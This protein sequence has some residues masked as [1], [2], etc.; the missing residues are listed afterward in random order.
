MRTSFKFAAAALAVSACLSFAAR[1]A[2]DAS[3]GADSK[4]VIIA[5]VNGEKVTRA[6]IEDSLARLPAQYRQYPPEVLFNLLVNSII[7]TKLA[8][9]AAVKEKLD[10]DQGFKDQMAQLR[11]QV[12][13]KVYMDRHIDKALTDEKLHEAYDIYVKENPGKEEVRGSHIL[14]ET[15]EQAQEIIGRL[16]KGEDFATLAKDLSKGPSG[17]AGGDLGY[18]T[19]DQMVPE[20]SEAA[21]ALK[22]GEI[23]E[24]PVRTQFGWHVIKVVDHRTA[25]PPSFEE[26]RDELRK[27]VSYD[28]ATAL[29][30]KLHDEAKVVRYDADG[31]PIAEQPERSIRPVPAEK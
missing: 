3:K 18:F 10:Q 21:F 26:A 24:K 17:R 27:K 29:M 6:D 5:T 9:A 23:T 30:K 31:N 14:V 25:P 1:A 19:R 22:V 11:E 4:T 7:D 15:E 8:A 2:E 13:E 20:F 12:L 28:V 16:K